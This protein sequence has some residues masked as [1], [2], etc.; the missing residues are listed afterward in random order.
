MTVDASSATN[1]V[2]RAISSLTIP[3]AAR[4]ARTGNYAA[5]LDLVDAIEEPSSAVRLLR[6]RVLAQAGDV[7]SARSEFEALLAAGPRRV[8]GGV[9]IQRQ[10]VAVRAVGGARHILC[11]VVQ[12]QRDEVVVGVDIRFHLT[13]PH[14]ARDARQP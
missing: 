7:E 10:R 3:V 11:P 13:N 1:S 9:D 6:G 8:R 5:A 2:N 4:L 12:L 14:R